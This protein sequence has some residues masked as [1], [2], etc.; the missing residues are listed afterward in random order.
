MRTV[1]ASAL[2]TLA[3]GVA[4]AAGTWERNASWLQEQIEACQNRSEEFACRYFPARA[5]KQLFGMGEFCSDDRCLLSH[6]MAARIAKDTQWAALG[7]ASDQAILTQA[8]D[9][10]TGGLPVIAVHAGADK[11]LIAIVMPGKLLAAQSWSMKVPLAVG[12]RVDKPES[13]VYGKG[14]NFL[15]SDPAKVTLYAYK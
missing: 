9:M 4:V 5:F 7:S 11:G 2:L 6:E 13:S 1:A 14:L 12:T 3:S 10:A 8:H 15:F